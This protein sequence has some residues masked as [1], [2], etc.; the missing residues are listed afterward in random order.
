MEEES[1]A[2]HKTMQKLKKNKDK[3]SNKAKQLQLE[4]ER[5]R[6]ENEK[7]K[8]LLKQAR[9][10]AVAIKSSKVIRKPTKMPLTMHN[11]EYEIKELNFKLTQ[12]ENELSLI[13]QQNGLLKGENTR[14]REK[15]ESKC[16]ECI[17]L[18]NN[19][20]D[21]KT[22]MQIENERLSVALKNEQFKLISQ[23]L[24]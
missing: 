15:Y 24:V 1:S 13:T 3:V 9:M 16:D 14:L 7:M 17:R 5:Q 18:N 2:L 4:L 10:E 12:M 6:Q 11:R 21:W 20:D 22:A 19:I 23:R 8:Q